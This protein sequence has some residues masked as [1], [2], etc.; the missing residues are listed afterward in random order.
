M[1]H[2]GYGFGFFPFGLISALIS[3]LFIVAI[4]VLVFWAVRALGAPRPWQPMAAPPAGPPPGSPLDI[5]ARR[6][7]AGEIT[8]E[9][10]QRARDVL[11]EPPPA[12]R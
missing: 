3:L 7:A 2:H 6:F 1:F 5:L 12:P 9:E 8:A 11:R 10:Y 4:V